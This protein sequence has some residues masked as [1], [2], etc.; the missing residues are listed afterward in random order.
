MSTSS[1]I[2]CASPANAI[3]M[4]ISGGRKARPPSSTGVNAYNGRIAAMRTLGKRFVGDR[5]DLRLTVGNAEEHGHGEDEHDL[6][7]CPVEDLPEGLLAR[8][9]AMRRFGK[10]KEVEEGGRKNERA[11]Y[12]AGQRIWVRS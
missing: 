4:A 12:N 8:V 2:D 1:Q 3:R 11:S 5:G 7:Q 10:E 9:L 6:G